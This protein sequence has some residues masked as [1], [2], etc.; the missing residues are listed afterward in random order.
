V[1]GTLADLPPGQSFDTLL[2][3]DVLEHIERDAAEMIR[4][5][6]RLND[7]GH[8]IVLAPAHP[9]LY[10]PFDAAVGHFRRYTR[11]SLRAAAPGGLRERSMRYLDAAGLL[12]SAANRLLLGQAM[13]TLHQILFWDRFLIPVSR[14]ADRLLGGSLGKSVLGVWER[15]GR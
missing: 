1:A 3:I 15:T 2:Y 13:P 10:T 12:A 4:A 8:L 14:V 7:G 6:D 5:R 9:F 11:S